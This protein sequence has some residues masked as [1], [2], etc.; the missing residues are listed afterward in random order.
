MRCARV[1]RG[2]AA[3]PGRAV[4]AV[5]AVV[6]VD[7]DPSPDVVASRPAGVAVDLNRR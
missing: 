2:V 1:V 4:A 5:A 7:G 6:A 3:V